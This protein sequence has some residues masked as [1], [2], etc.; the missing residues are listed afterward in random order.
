[1]LFKYFIEFDDDGEIK[2]LYKSQAECKNCKEYLVKLIPI[3]RQ[4]EDDIKKK[5]E[6]ENSNIENLLK[7][8]SSGRRKLETEL[9]KTLKSLR[10]LK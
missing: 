2:S 5:L 10:R 9:N 4:L 1:M 7:D 3:D 8:I 6:Q